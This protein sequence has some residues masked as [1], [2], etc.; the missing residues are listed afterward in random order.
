MKS[1][2]TV[3]EAKRY[4]V[5]TC[6]ADSLL[7]DAARQMVQR[8]ISCLVVVDEDGFLSGVISRMDLLRAYYECDDGCITKVVREYMSSDVVTVT[9]ETR[10]A[11][12]VRLM[13]DNHI[14][15]IVV[16]REENGKRRP[17]SILSDGDFM[18]HMVRDHE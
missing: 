11:D 4:G 10:L 14:H 7:L 9:P 15:R 16:V 12:V 3:L 1:G 17:V 18:Y 2:R 13:L 5:Y 6:Q 8:D